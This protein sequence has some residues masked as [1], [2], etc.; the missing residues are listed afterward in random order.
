MLNKSTWNYPVMPAPESSLA[1][2]L[3]MRILRPNANLLGARDLRGDDVYDSAGEHL[4]RIVEIL[5]NVRVGCVAWAVVSVGGFL[6]IGRRRFAIPWN[7]ISPDAQYKRC[8]LTIDKGQLMAP[9][10]IPT[11]DVPLQR[12]ASVATARL[13]SNQSEGVAPTGRRPARLDS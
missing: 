3:F 13:W 7:V 2:R 6:G 9:P 1:S 5:V 4:G 12:A 8:S 11:V 10:R